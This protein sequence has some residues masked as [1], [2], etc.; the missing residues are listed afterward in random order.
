MT[1]LFAAWNAVAQRVG[2]GDRL[3]VFTDFDGTLA[4]IR[5][6]AAQAHLSGRVRRA[7]ERLTADG[8][9]VAVVSGR[10]LEDLETRV[11]I[12][13]VWYAGSH[14]YFLRAPDGA[15]LSLLRL[16]ERRR[17]VRVTRRLVVALESMPGVSVEA[18][19]GTVA[20]HYRAATPAVRRQVGAA[21]RGLLSDD[22]GP[23]VV[24]GPD[25]V[26]SAARRSRRQIPGYAI[27]PSRS[28]PARSA[29]GRLADV[30]R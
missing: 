7:L 1:H 22:P 8:H 20:I 4:P 13:G 12:A 18:K 3:A 25:G 5:R 11:G 30:P 29:A 27:H 28:P 9:L 24:A 2:S 21:V 15:R 17:I 16:D 6:R 23:Q 10:P 14:G 26:G 19:P